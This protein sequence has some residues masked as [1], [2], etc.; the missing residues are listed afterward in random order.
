VVGTN[1]TLNL[2]YSAQGNR[3]AATLTGHHGARRGKHDSRGFSSHGDR[4][5]AYRQT[6]LNAGTRWAPEVSCGETTAAQEGAKEV[7]K[8]VAAAGA[9][10]ESRGERIAGLLGLGSV[11]IEVLGQQPNRSG[12]LE[13]CVLDG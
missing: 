3:A 9:D 4:R 2:L 11:F 12:N 8:G 10:I 6:P 13:R 7:A 1:T 5:I